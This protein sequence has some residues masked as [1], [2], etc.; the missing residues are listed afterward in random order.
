MAK[1]IMF[2]L[3]AH[4]VGCVWF[5]VGWLSIE[6]AKASAASAGAEA[7]SATGS[8]VLKPEFGA[9]AVS[10]G[11]FG[12]SWLL[13]EFGPKHES[14]LNTSWTI[15]SLASIESTSLQEQ[16]G[17]SQLYFTSLYWSFTMLMKSPH[18]GPDTW[19]EK[20]FGCLMVRARWPRRPS[21]SQSTV[22]QYLTPKS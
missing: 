6:M 18:I 4:W 1:L 14:L 8:L 21:P 16:V 10:S 5:L 3:V 17:V 7:I 19:L 12:D 11:W 13:R 9:F 20:L 2:V 22:L 15:A